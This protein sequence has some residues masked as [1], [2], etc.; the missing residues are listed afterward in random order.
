M[1]LS[2]EPGK[3]PPGKSPSL[4]LPPPRGDEKQETSRK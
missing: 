1:G 4:L 2:E 3:R